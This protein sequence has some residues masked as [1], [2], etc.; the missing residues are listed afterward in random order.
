MTRKKLLRRSL[1]GALLVGALA[2]ASCGSS[3]DDTSSDQPAPT[4]SASEDAGEATSTAEESTS[5]D[6]AGD[7][8]EGDASDDA[9]VDPIKLR[10]GSNSNATG[11]PVWTAIEQGI[12]ADHGLDVSYETVGSIATL[13][14]A[15][16]TS[17]D[18]VLATPV[19]MIAAA[20]QGIDVMW[21]A[22]G[23][24]SVEGNSNNH[25]IVSKDSG[26]T[27]IAELK[28]KTIGASSLTGTANLSTLA[29]L[30]KEGVNPDEVSVIQLDLPIM[31]DQLAAGRIDAVE[32]QPPYVEQM[33]SQGHIDLGMPYLELAPEIQTIFWVGQ[34][35]WANENPEAVNRYIAALEESL[36]WIEAN[37]DA[38]REIL[39]EYA[40]LSAEVAANTQ[41]PNYSLETRLDDLTVWYNAMVD[42]G[43]YSGDEPD[44]PSLVFSGN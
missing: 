15:L 18:I 20:S 31:A 41:L 22:G 27:S 24:L 4:S 8:A 26:I 34:S 42:V 25:V 39:Q 9:T 36:E 33:I 19:G 29:W 21:L 40:G 38:A 7:D 10:I 43:E 3:S 32:T 13:V 28:G 35:A 12:F 11:L 1:F 16:G 44:L 2:A 17:F 5:D 37:N 23:S 30:K 6:A 14:P